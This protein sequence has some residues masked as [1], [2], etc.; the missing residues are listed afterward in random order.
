MKE[1]ILA[2]FQMLGFVDKVQDPNSITAEQWAQVAAAYEE[3]HGTPLATDAQSEVDAAAQ[4][5]L[6]VN[7][8]VIATLSEN[9][10]SVLASTPIA[11]VPSAEPVSPAN[12]SVS[13]STQTPIDSLTASVT[14]LLGVFSQLANSP[15]P[16]VA[17]TLVVNSGEHTASHLFGIENEAYS[18]NRR[19]NL[20]SA[21]PALV[22]NSR[23]SASEN[24][25]LTSAVYNELASFSLSIADR[26][27]MQLSSATIQASMTPPTINTPTVNHFDN[28]IISRQDA[29]ITHLAKFKNIYELFPRFYGVQDKALM[30]NAFF[31][32]FSQAY[33]KGKVFKGS[34]TLS[35]EIAYVDDAMFKHEFGSYKELE[36][37]Y[38][39]YLN[40]EGSAAIKWTFIE[41]CLINIAET[42]LLEQ[43][44][45]KI[46][47]CYV[48][49]EENMPGHSMHTGNGVLITLLRYYKEHKVL[50]F[51]QDY[52]SGGV[53][54]G[55]LMF[56]MIE[57][58]VAKV[59]EKV[60]DVNDFVIFANANHKPAYLK[61]IR[62]SY[63]TDQDWTAQTST[64]F[65]TQVAIKWVPYMYDLPMVI[66]SK[67]GNIQCIENVAG[68]MLSL[69]FD[70]EME[71]VLVWSVW[72][73]G[74]AAY[75][76]GKPFA[77]RESLEADDMASQE[78]FF[79]LPTITSEI[80]ATVIVAKK[81]RFVYSPALNTASKTITDIQG[82]LQG[83]F[84]C[85]ENNHTAFV[86]EV[87]KSGKFEGI[88]EAYAPV[89]KGDYLLVVLN[90][91][92]DK[93]LELERCVNGVRKIN[94]AKL[95][96][97]TV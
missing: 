66:I 78:I 91:A 83:A 44:K 89:A 79:N 67:P 13:A 18:L 10:M 48:K 93:F 7:N 20:A 63:G 69:S 55:A 43:A 57:E 26:M 4:A 50:P 81:N 11:G 6:A 53:V 27:K 74:V 2:I 94:K 39:G 19:W 46:F 64:F 49:P 77:T 85:I 15:A 35:P 9:V 21:N 12:S 47:G 38:L 17:Q 23:I 97:V 54:S 90:S 68:E 59:S 37:S 80:D 32:N 25:S 3:T 56:D 36:R 96:N 31:G 33:Q 5:Q 24:K 60:D 75:F 61:H 95:P 92:G 84:Y 65:D 30:T 51:I 29:I 28:F 70:Q 16:D 62:E 73:E 88:T 34:V 58:M 14:S 22:D 1:K 42:L 87:A 72:K 52:T 8:S 71:S 86:S 76:A 82:A 45:R 40:K 41:W